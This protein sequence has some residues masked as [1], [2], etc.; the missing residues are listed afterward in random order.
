MGRVD[1]DDREE[2]TMAKDGDVALKVLNRGQAIKEKCLDCSGG[3][4]KEVERCP[5]KRC[6]LYPYR[7][8]KNPYS[9]R[10]GGG[11]PEALRRYKESVKSL[12]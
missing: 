2:V 12:E 7:L 9:K 11:N 4:R 5:I 6:A 1:A 3:S 10:K 8:G